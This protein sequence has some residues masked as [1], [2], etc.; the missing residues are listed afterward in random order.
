MTE[1]PAVIAGLRQRLARHGG[2]RGATA[3]QPGNDSLAVDRRF[4]SA[5]PAAWRQHQEPG[6][7]DRVGQRRTPRREC[8]ALRRQIRGRLPAVVGQLLRFS[9]QRSQRT[10]RRSCRRSRAQQHSAPCRSGVTRPSG[11]V[12]KIA[13]PHCAA[14]KTNWPAATSKTSSNC[15]HL[16]WQHIEDP[17]AGI[18]SKVQLSSRGPQEG[19]YCLE[20]SAQA[21]TASSGPKIVARPLVWITSPP[22]RATAGEAARNLRLG[23][24]LAA[25]QRQHRRTRNRRFARRA[26]ALAPRSQ[27]QR[28]GN[29]FA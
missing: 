14:A 19:R 28:I 11:R 6:S 15:K 29:R 8:V 18:Q 4:C 12:R 7:G 24:R 20:L 1:D 3:I 26:R 23:P 13:A 2:A 21:A 22:V 10:R 25:N 27:H 5:T 9:R 16:G 17:I